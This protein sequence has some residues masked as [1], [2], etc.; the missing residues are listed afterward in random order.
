MSSRRREIANS[1]VENLKKIDGS[2]SDFDSTYIYTRNLYSKV[3]RKIVFPNEINDYPAVF[4]HP[5]TETRN[6]ETSEF[7]T[8]N[9][10]IV[11]YLYVNEEDP[12]SAIEEISQDIEHV[13]YHLTYNPTLKI[14]D[15]NIESITT[16]E[17]LLAPFGVGLITINVLYN[18]EA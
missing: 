16:D 15:I 1:I 6:Y 11:I 2:I 10:P 18:L 12:V 5:G 9:L 14:E 3:E 17:G 13:L 4:I 7:T 8:A